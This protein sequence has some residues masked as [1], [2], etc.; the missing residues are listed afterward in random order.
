MKLSRK[1]R[2]KI[3]LDI[4]R[5]GQ[6]LATKGSYRSVERL[7]TMMR[8]FFRTLVPLRCRLRTYIRCAGLEP[9]GLVDAYFER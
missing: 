7:R 3:T 2:K 4:L 9:D 8:V 6:Y 5:V 1:I